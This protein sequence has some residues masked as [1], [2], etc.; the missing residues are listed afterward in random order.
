[1]PYTVVWS[2]S[3][4][5]ELADIWNNSAD[6]QAVTRATDRIDRRLRLSPE[7]AGRPY[8]DG[9][10]LVFPPLAVTFTIHPDD[11][12]VEVNHVWRW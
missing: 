6:Q 10:Y 1:M 11:R 2:P 3:A 4:V 8:G 5:A 7:T 9:R 12:R